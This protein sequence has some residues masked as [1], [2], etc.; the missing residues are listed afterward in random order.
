MQ[1]FKQVMGVDCYTSNSST[2]EEFGRVPMPILREICIDKY[3]YSKMNTLDSLIYNIIF[4]LDTKNVYINSLTKQVKDML[5][6]LGFYNL[7]NI[8]CIRPSQVG[9]II[10]RMY[11]PI[12]LA[13]E[14]RRTVILKI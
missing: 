8:E 12:C 14:Y 7:W 1:C 5:F 6:S 10:Q 3:W 11:A 13:V 2:Y 4:A 9:V